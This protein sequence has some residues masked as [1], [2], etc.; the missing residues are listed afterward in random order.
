MNIVYPSNKS[1]GMTL[2]KNPGTTLYKTINKYM[3]NI[4]KNPGEQK[5]RKINLENPT[6]KKRI[7]NTTGGIYL[8]ELI[9][10]A[11]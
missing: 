8:M 5:F 4:L 3:S 11:K 9:G 7:V 10:F 2:L 6:V 1:K